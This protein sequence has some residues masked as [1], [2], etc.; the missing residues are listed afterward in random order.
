MFFDV[1]DPEEKINSQEDKLDVKI[2][3]KIIGCNFEKKHMRN[4]SLRRES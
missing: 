1:F 4:Y 2:A 3:K